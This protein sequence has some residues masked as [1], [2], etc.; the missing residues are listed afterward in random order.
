MIGQ[1]V[2]TLAE[3]S[4]LTQIHPST[5]RTWFK[6]RADGTGLGSVFQSDYQAVDGDCAVS[7]LDLIE[8]LVAGQFRS[9]YEV[10]MRIVR[11]AH[12][13]LQKDLAADH[14]FC[15]ADLY[16][17]IEEDVLNAVGFEKQYGRRVA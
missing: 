3:V 16:K 8:S 14:P 17:I 6:G 10:S 4:K 13:I 9:R 7:F 1:G 12:E 2:Y 15:H 11:R 5:I